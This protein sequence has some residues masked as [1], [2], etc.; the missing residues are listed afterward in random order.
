MNIIILII[1]VIL[2]IELLLRQ[3]HSSKKTLS[4]DIKN[5]PF[6]RRPKNF[7]GKEAYSVERS[8]GNNVPLVRTYNEGIRSE[9][10]KKPFFLCVGCSFT[11]GIGIE[12]SK[13]FPSYLQNQKVLF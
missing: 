13:T 8:G 4:F 11:E 1:L 10:P 2:I 5:Y 7:K 3:Y 12:D 6:Y 9:I